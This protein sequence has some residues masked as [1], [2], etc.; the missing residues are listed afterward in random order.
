VFQR[1]I[2]RVSRNVSLLSTLVLALVL[3]ASSSARGS[4]QDSPTA[5]ADRKAAFDLFDQNNYE[6]ALPLLEQVT[7]TYPNDPAVWEHLGFCLNA[8]AVSLKDPE[9]RRQTRLRARQAFLRAKALGDNSNL[10]QTSLEGIPEDGGDAPY[11]DKKEIDDAMRSAETA[12]GKGD[13]TR[14][15]AGYAEVLKLD[16]RNYQAE[17]F[18]G[19]AC[20][21]LKDYETSFKWFASAVAIDPEQEIAYRYW[22]DAL[23]AA[24]KSK[25][26]REKF[27]EAI[28]ASPYERR[29][30]VGLTQWAD[31]TG[32]KLTQPNIQSPNSLSSNG[33]TTN[34]TIDASTLGKKDG[35]ESWM[36]YEI[37]RAGFQLKFHDHFPNE[38]EYRHSLAEESDA[39]GLVAGTLTQNIDSKK[40]KSADLTP[41]L[42]ILLKIKSEGLLE[43]YIL[44]SA[45]DQ[46]IA[47]DYAAYR[48]DHRDKLFQYMDEYVVPPA[49]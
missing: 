6:D 43:P 47:S 16:P 10:L 40:I 36:V 7:A 11:S 12:F 15:L 42:A 34:I 39:L 45:A 27:I 25:E 24:G 37:A 29:A 48:K 33:S 31:R 2:L 19:D 22:G 21:K 28:V 46:G 41:A 23:Y 49:Q 8:H 1:T 35:S 32:V 18:S 9:A 26:A 13:L 20:F 44:I 4:A 3:T 17:L 5:A 30:W 38:T 14:A